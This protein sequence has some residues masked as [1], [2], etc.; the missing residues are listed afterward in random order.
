MRR[1]KKYANLKSRTKTKRSYGY[2]GI[3]WTY[4]ESKKKVEELEKQVEYG[5]DDSNSLPL[6]KK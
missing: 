5:R 2:A 3:G 1:M 4:E 6:I